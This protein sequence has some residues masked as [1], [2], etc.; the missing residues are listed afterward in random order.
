MIDT[1]LRFRLIA[2]KYEVHMKFGQ[3]LGVEG[4]LRASIRV[5]IVHSYYIYTTQ[6]T[7]NTA[8]DTGTYH[9]IYGYGNKHGHGHGQR[10]SNPGLDGS[11]TGANILRLAQTLKCLKY[12]FV[13]RKRN[14][15]QVPYQT[16]EPKKQQSAT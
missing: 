5:N 11:E 13:K 7:D 14:T 2:P 6:E 9:K 3:L 16:K 12:R 10:H 8:T 4:P 1:L 15:V